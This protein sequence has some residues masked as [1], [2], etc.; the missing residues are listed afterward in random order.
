MK[1]NKNWSCKKPRI[2]IRPITPQEIEAHIR[3]LS[4][5]LLEGRAVGSRGLSLAVL[6]QE[7]YFRSLGLEP[8]FGLSFSQPLVLRGSQP[9]KAASMEIFSDGVSLNFEI[10]P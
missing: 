3:F 2:G 4:D 8:V 7:N 10:H 6:Y 5:D 9:D 1:G